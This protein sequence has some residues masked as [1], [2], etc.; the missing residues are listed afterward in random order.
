MKVRHHTARATSTPP[1]ASLWP[2]IRRSFRFT[3]GS[4]LLA[5]AIATVAALLLRLLTGLPTP[6]E[7][8]GDRITILIPLPIFSRLLQ[9]FGPNAKHVFFVT[10]VLGEF[11][12][13]ALAGALYYAVAIYLGTRDD[14]AL[15]RLWDTPLLAALLWV[16][17]AGILAPVIGA[18]FLGAGL[19]GGAGA[20]LRSEL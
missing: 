9:L 5:S 10:L 18:G 11:V 20:V 6:A 4:A 3:W 8:F 1:R 2:A 16:A 7:L 12:L 13:T 17:S 14:T 15:A 19:A